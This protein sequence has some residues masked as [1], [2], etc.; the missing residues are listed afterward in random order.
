MAQKGEHCRIAT[1][2][3]HCLVHNLQSCELS[4]VTCQQM[5]TT[6][7][8]GLS[9]Y[10]DHFESC[11]FLVVHPFLELLHVTVVASQLLA[12]TTS[13]CGADFVLPAVLCL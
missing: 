9:Y 12:S 11:A 10:S 1:F 3:L 8:K 2:L 5:Q 13:P 4:S 7:A 6:V